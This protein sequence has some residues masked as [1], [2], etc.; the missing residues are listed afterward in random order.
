VSLS[1]VVQ[2]AILSSTVSGPC[3][4]LS[5]HGYCGREQPVTQAMRNYMLGRE[6]AHEIGIQQ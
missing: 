1:D 5:P 4:P 6:F 2:G 3:D